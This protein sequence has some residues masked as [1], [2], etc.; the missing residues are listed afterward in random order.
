MLCVLWITLILSVGVV[1]LIQRVKDARDIAA[2][3]LGVFAVLA[4]HIVVGVQQLEFRDIGEKINKRAEVSKNE[5]VSAD[6]AWKEYKKV[7]LRNLRFHSNDLHFYLSRNKRN[8][9]IF[10]FIQPCC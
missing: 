3:G 1:G 4:L 2:D 5:Y 10:S 7:Y 6:E 8:T 9:V